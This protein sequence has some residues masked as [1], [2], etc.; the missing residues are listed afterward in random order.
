MTAKR[1]PAWP[2]VD[3]S[4]GFP[5]VGGTERRDLDGREQ[6]R[7]ARPAQVRVCTFTRC[8]PTLRAAGGYTHTCRRGVDLG[9]GRGV[10]PLP[11]TPEGR[12]AGA[13]E[14]QAKETAA[15]HFIAVVGFFCLFRKI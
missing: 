4:Q 10:H 13:M 12:R 11:A 8:R 6:C 1:D 5:G 2:S 3:T 9:D 7:V 15:F 14:E